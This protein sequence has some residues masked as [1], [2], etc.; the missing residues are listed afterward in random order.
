MAD[1][2][3]ADDDVEA[4]SPPPPA[5]GVSFASMARLGFAATGPTLGSS[6]QQGTPL[7][8]ICLCGC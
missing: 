5:N 8:S 3:C 4:G 2:H 6:P 7:S 1:N